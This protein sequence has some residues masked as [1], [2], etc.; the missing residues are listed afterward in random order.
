MRHAV[1]VAAA[2]AALAAVAPTGAGADPILP[3]SEVRPGM[4]GEARTVITGTN[5]E[6][7]PVRVLGVQRAA[8]TPGGTLIL[9]RAEGPLITPI[10]VAEGM[11]GSPVYVTGADGVQRVIGAIAFGTG[12]E[13][14]LVV[15]VTPIESM[16]SAARLGGV[17][18]G[19]GENSRPAAVRAA[20][21]AALVDG[22]A[23]AVRLERRHPGR[24][25]LYPLRRWIVGGASAPVL[26]PLAKRLRA[27][28]IR[29]TATPAATSPVEAPLVPGASMSALLSAGDLAVGAIGT[30]T[31]VDGRT[32]IGFGHPFLGAGATRFLLAGGDIVATIAA[33]L[34]D[35]SYKL[36]VPTGLRGMIV[37]DRTDGIVG[38]IG[39]VAGIPATS[40]AID[41]D[42]ETDLTA[43]STLAPDRRA[44]TLLAPVVQGEPAFA[45][46]DGI[47]G[48]TLR[49]RI[50]VRSPAF[51]RPLV[52]RN[53]YAAA[54]DVISLANGELAR[55]TTV[56][57]QNGIRSISISSID[58]VQTLE[59]RVRAARIR[60][61]RIR[62]RRARAGQRVTL[63]MVIA[64]WR[65][66]LRRVRRTVRLPGD[67]PPGPISLRVVANGAGGFDGSL[68]PLDGELDDAAAPVRMRRALRDVNRRARSLTGTRTERLL[69]AVRSTGPRR[70]DAVRILLPGEFADDPSVGIPVRVGTVISGGR[71]VVRASIR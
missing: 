69:E 6:R 50:T 32:V 19:A 65:G 16:I 63:D 52:Y 49:L 28:G 55:I 42:R 8:A 17:P 40:R 36:G 46:R 31:Y 23:A 30:V 61:A 27:E 58:V 5:I 53:T 18:L 1:A 22:R 4:T 11:S 14:G 48:G 39:G 34:N 38:R 13:G 68:A 67:L 51:R 33:P 57:A 12:D 59:K 44:L 60:S 62:P 66:P 15:G 2:A 43:R 29:A 21:P 10:G 7:F 47:E 54:G 64:N 71:A 70:N 9:V 35:S 41:R 25:A 3:L 56:L 26:G 45:V 24:R 37:G 20:R